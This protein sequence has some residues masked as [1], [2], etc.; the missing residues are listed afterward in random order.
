MVPSRRDQDDDTARD[1]VTLAR[2]RI[3]QTLATA[4]SIAGVVTLYRAAQAWSADALP[5]TVATQV[6]LAFFFVGLG[7]AS[8]Y[9][10]LSQRVDRGDSQTSATTLR[11]WA[12]L[13]SILLC[14]GAVVALGIWGLAHSQKFPAPA[15]LGLALGIALSRP[16][17]QRIDLPPE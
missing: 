4:A 6:A 13:S 7:P 10:V 2:S 9:H 1:E 17:I 5:P 8:R 11:Q 16:A 15:L 14:G 12:M 3:Y